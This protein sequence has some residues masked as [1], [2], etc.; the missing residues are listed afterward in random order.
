VSKSE[1]A[2][3]TWTVGNRCTS[4]ETVADP[5]ELFDA[6]TSTTGFPDMIVANPDTNN[7]TQTRKQQSLHESAQMEL[8]Q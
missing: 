8:L 6:V 4:C 1:T 5:T 7:K 2:A 3:R